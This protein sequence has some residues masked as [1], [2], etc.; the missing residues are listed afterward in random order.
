[1]REED[2]ARSL[3]QF[4]GRRICRRRWFAPDPRCQFNVSE[5]E[6]ARRSHQAHRRSWL[7]DRGTSLL[8][9]AA[10]LLRL[11]SATAPAISFKIRPGGRRIARASTAT[12]SPTLPAT[13]PSSATRRQDSRERAISRRARASAH[14]AACAIVSPNPRQFWYRTIAARSS[15]STRDSNILAASE[16]VPPHTVS[17]FTSM[18]SQSLCSVVDDASFCRGPVGG[19][20]IR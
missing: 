16:A 7:D 18:S 9:G 3:R 11:S 4:P 2:S 20:R 1:M 17:L 10:G 5:R 6:R 14:R 8:A 12:T 13:M 15:S 19:L